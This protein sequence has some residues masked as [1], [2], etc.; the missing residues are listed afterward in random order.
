MKLKVGEEEV[1][2]IYSFRSSVYFEQITGH[3]IDF[4]KLSQND[5]VTLFYCIF[6]ASLQK[7]KKPIVTMLDFLDIIDDN[8]GDKAILDFSN[9]FIDVMKAQYEVLTDDNDKKPKNV[10]KKKT[11]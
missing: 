5:L 6:I 8:G 3:N 4:A 2:L 7:S 11:N 10:S 9:W 1:E